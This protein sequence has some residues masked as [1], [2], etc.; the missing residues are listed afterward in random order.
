[1]LFA[2]F[3]VL[4]AGTVLAKLG[5]YFFPGDAVASTLL[6]TAVF[7]VLLISA[8][9]VFFKIAGFGSPFGR[10]SLRVCFVGCVF[11]LYS[12]VIVMFLGSVVS[13]TYEIFTGKC[14]APQHV[15]EILGDLDGPF[16][17]A[18][19]IFSVVFLA[20]VSEELVFRGTLYRM[21]KAWFV[22]L[23]FSTI[24]SAWV[25]AGASALLF[26]SVH[27][28][29]FAFV[30]LAAMG[31]ILVFAYEKSSSIISPM[32]AHSLFNCANVALLFASE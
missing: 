12:L 3:S 1:M 24:F 7:Q 22:H 25:S 30:P 21:S 23:G 10:L 13:L 4:Y 19:G 15:V 32:I 11:F 18:L 9:F 26:A 8:I 29:L 27:A 31:V 2:F 14:P 17:F 6:P 28:N 20:P 16:E 5:A